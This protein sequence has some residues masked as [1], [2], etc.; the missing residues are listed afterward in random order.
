MPAFEYIDAVD[1]IRCPL[2]R[3]KL[4]SM[5][6]AVKRS[7]A[8]L[9]AAAALSPAATGAATAAEPKV[10]LLDG[11]QLVQ[12]RQRVREGDKNLAP[13]M[14]ELIQQANR[15]LTAGPFSVVNKDVTPPSGD[16]RDYMSLAPY[17]W[18]NPATPGGL[19]YIR[20]DGE[21]NPEIH[22][23]RNRLDLGEMVDAVETLALAYFFTADEKYASRAAILIRHW[24]LDPATGMNPNLKYAQA[25][26]GVNEGRGEGL[27]ETRTLTRVVDSIGLLAGSRARLAEDQQ[28]CEEWFSQFLDWMLTSELGRDEASSE[29]NH[30]TFYDVQVACYALFLG[31]QDIA[32]KILQTAGDRRIAVQIAPDGSQPLELNRTKAWSYSVGNLAGLMALARLAEHVDVDLWRYDTKD[33]RSIRKALDFLAPFG[34]G[35]RA[36]PHRQI[37]GFSPDIFYP[38][39]RL[40]AA[41]YPNGP[42]GNTLAKLPLQSATAGA[43]WSSPIEPINDLHRR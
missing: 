4:V 43:L 8:A 14:A 21:R 20:R 33:G 5:F 12:A 11:S 3:G 23:L 10:F 42:Y 16:K 32:R 34:I 36:W 15:A 17:W 22:K 27:I 6:F 18:P 19:P 39:L 38:L 41:K 7:V 35:D 37:K 13:A 29:N 24:F 26:R 2:A 28:G 31:K 25:I 1:S 30:G 9:I 40:A